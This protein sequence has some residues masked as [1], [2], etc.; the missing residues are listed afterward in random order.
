MSGTGISNSD[1]PAQKDNAKAEAVRPVA[2]RIAAMDA[3]SAKRRF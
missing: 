2:K 3:I 1:S